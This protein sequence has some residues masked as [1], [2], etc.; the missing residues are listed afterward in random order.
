MFRIGRKHASHAYPTSR[1]VQ[2]LPFARNNATGPVV[3]QPLTTALATNLTWAFVASTG[4]AGPNVPI[5]PQVTGDALVEVVVNVANSDAAV[6]T[7]TVAVA[8]GGTPVGP[9]SLVELGP[10]GTAASQVAIP[11]L[12][13]LSGLPLGTPSDITVQVTAS[14]GNVLSISATRSAIS[15]REVGAATG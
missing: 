3:N 13:P 5:T 11:V 12:V 9:A 15:V 1:G 8:V 6:H 10:T 2:A 4:E 7:V 14:A